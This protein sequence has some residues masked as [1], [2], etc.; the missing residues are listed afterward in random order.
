MKTATYFKRPAMRSLLAAFAL[1]FAVQSAW[2][3]DLREAKDQG[4]VGEARSGYLA[5]RETPVS[6]EVRALISSVNT[7]RKARFE[8]TARNTNTTVAQVANRFYELAVQKT[9]RGHYYQ[10]ANGRWVKK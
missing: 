4:L 8:R 3:I 6:K 2:A 1:F 10:D 7:K 5:A 9:R